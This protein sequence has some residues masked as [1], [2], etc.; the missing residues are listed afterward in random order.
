MKYVYQ[1][2]EN[3]WKKFYRLSSCQKESVRVLWN[4]FK[5][6]PFDPRLG[7]HRINSLSAQFKKTIYSVV[8][9]AD[10]RVVFYIEED[11]VWTIDI[12]T[13]AIYK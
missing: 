10:L 13:H 2:S 9:E 8:V 12:G 5:E 3:F 4:I 1:A 7:T 6:N 11:T